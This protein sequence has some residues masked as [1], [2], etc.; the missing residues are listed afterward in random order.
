MRCHINLDKEIEADSFVKHQAKGL[1]QI[2]KARHLK[3]EPTNLVLIHSVF[4]YFG[5]VSN[6]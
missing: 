3:V 6:Q 5:R 1:I 4:S 2:D